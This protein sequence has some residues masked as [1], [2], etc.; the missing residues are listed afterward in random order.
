MTPT[1][2]RCIHCTYIQWWVGFQGDPLVC[3]EQGG[4]GLLADGPRWCTADA[5]ISAGMR[6]EYCRSAALIQRHTGGHCCYVTI[7]RHY[8]SG[9][10]TAGDS[11]GW[12]VWPGVYSVFLPPWCEQRLI[13][14]LTMVP[15]VVIVI[16]W[17][18]T[19]I[20][21]ISSVMLLYWHDSIQRLIIVQCHSDI[22]GWR[23]LCS[24][25]GLSGP[26]VGREHRW[27]TSQAEFHASQFLRRWH[28]GLL[29]WPGHFLLHQSELMWTHFHT[30]PG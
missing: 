8:Q 20:Y 13:I 24:Y 4:G 6:S 29:W 15:F 19:V 18:I 17:Y 26:D 14:I 5:Q 21:R 10:H 11:S 7:I 2:N 23:C 28:R 25:F 22:S 3:V 1:G 27:A 30:L 12:T 9:T 16:Y